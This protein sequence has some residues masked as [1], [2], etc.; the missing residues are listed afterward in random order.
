MIIVRQ[1]GELNPTYECV[2]NLLLSDDGFV[3]MQ[4]MNAGKSKHQGGRPVRADLDLLAA[5]GYRK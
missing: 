5:S 1:P 2:I 4:P 3:S